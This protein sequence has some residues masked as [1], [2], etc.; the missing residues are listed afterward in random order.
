GALFPVTHAAAAE[1]AS[2]EQVEITAT[3]PAPNGRL[4]LDT[5]TETGGRLGL[6]PRETPASVNV[7]D[8]LTIEAR[9]AQDTQEILRA[10][11]GVTA[12]NAP[13]N[14]G[15]SYRGFGGGSIAQLFNGINVQYS[16][17]ARPVD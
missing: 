9:G 6:T 2:L 11:P 14:I 1:S 17:A 10:I 4:D 5:P 15:V 13:G 8:R 3:V 7:V 12:H 16:I